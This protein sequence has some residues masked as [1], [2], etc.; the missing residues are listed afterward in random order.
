MLADCVLESCTCYFW[1]R[2]LAAS[3]FGV[4]LGVGSYFLY[5]SFSPFPDLFLLTAGILTGLVGGVLFY[6]ISSESFCHVESFF[7][8]NESRTH[9][10]M[11]DVR[12]DLG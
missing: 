6:V 7:G 10:Y 4:I 12:E 9:P 3:I 8:K 2:R 1:E 5:V 11:G